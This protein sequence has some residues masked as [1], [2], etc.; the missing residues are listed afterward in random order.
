MLLGAVGGPGS[1]FIIV[2]VLL[3]AANTLLAFAVANYARDKGFP[4][5]P[6]L[7]AAMF[8]S[9]PATWLIVALMPP[10]SDS[11]F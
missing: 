4:F 3:V 11:R 7:V 10:P 8:F 1:W 5:V 6:V 9:V 2:V